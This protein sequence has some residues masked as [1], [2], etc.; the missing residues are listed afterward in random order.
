MA[1]KI[2]FI[3]G[4]SPTKLAAMLGLAKTVK[5]SL[6]RGE[7]ESAP[8]SFYRAFNSLFVTI[9]DNGYRFYIYTFGLR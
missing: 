1:Y 4:S 8:L 3:Q 9:I 7:Y 6:R 5:V 2:A